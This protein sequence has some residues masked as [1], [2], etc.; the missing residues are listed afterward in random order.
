MGFVKLSN[1]LSDWAWYNDNNTLA[2]YI[3]L[4]MGAVWQDACYQNAKLKRGQAATTIPKIAEQSG[5]T[6]QQTRTVLNRLKSTGKITVENTS[7]FSIIT[8]NDYDCDI[9]SNSQNN[10]PS[11]DEQQPTNWQT[12]DNQQAGNSS[13]TGNQQSYFIINRN[14]E[15]K[16]NRN[17]DNIPVCANGSAEEFLPSSNS[18]KVVR[19]KPKS[20]KKRFAEFVSMTNEEYSSLVTKLGEDGA[21]RCVEILDNYKGS[22]G[23]KYNSDY[24][25]ILNWVV[26]RYSEEKANISPNRQERNTQTA[27]RNPFINAVLGD[28]GE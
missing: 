5:L 2:V 15:D 21:K 17:T 3:R 7:K 13:S 18:K 10:S 19:Q 28:K 16:K 20:E 12:T 8:L 24:R 26:G 14:T 4:L 27:S 6:I 23:K 9:G 25:A 11:T 22:S 1:N